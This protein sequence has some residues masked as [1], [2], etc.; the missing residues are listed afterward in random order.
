M[1]KKDIDELEK[2]EFKLASIIEKEKRKVLNLRREY[3]QYETRTSRSRLTCVLTSVP[4][5]FLYLILIIVPIGTFMGLALGALDK[6]IDTL[7][8]RTKIPYLK[9]LYGLFLKILTELKG[10]ILSSDFSIPVFLLL[11]TIIVIGCIYSGIQAAKSVSDKEINWIFLLPIVCFIAGFSIPI[12]LI[13]LIV[14]IA[15]QIPV[16]FICFLILL[17]ILGFIPKK[18]DAGKRE[19]E[20]EN[21]QRNLESLE[22]KISIEEK[23]LDNWRAKL[24][25]NGVVCSYCKHKSN[26]VCN[27]NHIEGNS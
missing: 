7:A 19:K 3:S 24:H 16:V 27:R 23:I 2:L 12:A 8:I 11:A 10:W 5:A 26:I 1:E 6:T 14:T 9:G 4:F 22:K 20:M 25:T 17:I 13:S 18:D 21:I 15:W